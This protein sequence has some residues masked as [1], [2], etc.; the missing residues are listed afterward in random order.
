MKAADLRIKNLVWEDYG[1]VYEVININSEGFEYVD[2]R[3]PSFKAIGRY[4]IEQIKPIPLTEEWLLRFGF[5][6]KSFT[7]AFKGNKITC[8]TLELGSGFN[9]CSIEWDDNKKYCHINIEGCMEGL[10]I[11]YIHQLQNLY[12]AL[13]YQELIIKE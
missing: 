1:G 6:D 13:T 3:K 11:K 2:L 9:F 7:H 10:P 12:H 8:Y 5:T 4:V